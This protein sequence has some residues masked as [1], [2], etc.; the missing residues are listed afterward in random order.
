MPN[1]IVQAGA[2]SCAKTKIKSCQATPAAEDNGRPVKTNKAGAPEPVM[3]KDRHYSS[4]F[5]FVSISSAFA[6]YLFINALCSR[7]RRTSSSNPRH[8]HVFLVERSDVVLVAQV[9]LNL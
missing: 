4:S 9:P 5:P 1:T 8:R 2:H 7:R 6:M 3:K